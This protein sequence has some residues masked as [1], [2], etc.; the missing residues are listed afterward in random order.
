MTMTMPPHIFNR[1][2]ASCGCHLW[3]IR[4]KCELEPFT[5]TRDELGRFT[6]DKLF[7]LYTRCLNDEVSPIM[8]RRFTKATILEMFL[9]ETDSVELTP[10][11]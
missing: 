3:D 4:C 1:D 10:F 9:G 7:M 2:L 11:L 5:L 8:W 6:K